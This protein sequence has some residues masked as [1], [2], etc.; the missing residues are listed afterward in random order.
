MPHGKLVL[1]PT[2][3]LCIAATLSMITLC[4]CDF[5]KPENAS[6]YYYYAGF[7]GGCVYAPYS[8]NMSY[9]EYQ[10]EHR[11][12]SARK[13]AMSFGLIACIVGT[14]AMLALWPITCKPYKPCGIHIIGSFVVV[15]CLS[16]LGTLAML[17]TEY[18]KQSSFTCKLGWGGIMSIIAAVMWLISAIGVWVIP[19]H[20]I[21]ATMGGG[22]AATASRNQGGKATTMITETIQADGT[23]VTETVTTHADGTKTTEKVVE[24][25]AAVPTGGD[26]GVEQPAHDKSEA[27]HAVAL[28]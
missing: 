6:S 5:V 17:G 19:K 10:D 15:A 21:E 22:G 26:V 1:F 13:V 14:G 20:P 23:R 27:V 11:E 9:S 2:I 16:Q 24:R 28:P 4:N 8:S 25:S 7:W 18:C 3:M 12:D